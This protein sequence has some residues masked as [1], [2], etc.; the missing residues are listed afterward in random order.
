MEKSRTCICLDNFRVLNSR[1]V[2][3]S[4]VSIGVREVDGVAMY[5]ICVKDPC[6]RCRNLDCDFSAG[7]AIAKEFIYV[8][9]AYCSMN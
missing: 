5:R 4:R 1:I 3:G 2:G 9:D 8:T 6:T 7:L